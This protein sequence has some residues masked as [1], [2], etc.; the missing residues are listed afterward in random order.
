MEYHLSSTGPFVMAWELVF[1][2]AFCY[3]SECFAELGE[4]TGILVCFSS[5]II[6]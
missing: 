5:T 2:E 1:P 3:C 4:A 6:S